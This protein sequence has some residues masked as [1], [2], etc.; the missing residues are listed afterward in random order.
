MQRKTDDESALALIAWIEGMLAELE[1]AVDDDVLP[2]GTHG[3]LIALLVGLRLQLV[4]ESVVDT[5]TA[6][7]VV[8]LAARWQAVVD[9][10]DPDDLD[11]PGAT[12]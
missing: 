6:R 1:R 8:A 12:G 2:A 7:H 5:R 9:V 11:D 3:L 10:L 4:A